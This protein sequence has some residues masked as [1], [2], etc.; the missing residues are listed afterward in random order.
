MITW[1]SGSINLNI[2]GRYRYTAPDVPRPP[3]NA[4]TVLEAAGVLGNTGAGSPA[5]LVADITLVGTALA[6]L[7][8]KTLIEAE[9]TTMPIFQVTV[10]LTGGEEPIVRR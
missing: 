3:K 9:S 4:I 5:V 10:I 8:S 2:V 6:P 1:S 7:I